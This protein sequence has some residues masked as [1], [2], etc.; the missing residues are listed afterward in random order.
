[1]KFGSKGQIPYIEL[2]GEEIPDSN[3]IIARLKAH[4]GLD[5]D[6]DSSSTDLAMGH[7]ATGLVENHLAQVGFHY[8]YGHHMGSFLR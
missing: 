8:R 3:V 1:M 2:N 6:S 5:P 7:A 4:F